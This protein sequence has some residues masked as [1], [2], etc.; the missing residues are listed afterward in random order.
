MGSVKILDCT[1]RDGGCV[2]DFAFGSKNIK[3]ILDC[4]E[5]SNVEIIECGYIDENGFDGDRTKFRSDEVLNDKYLRSRGDCDKYYVAM[6]DYGKFDVNN[7]IRKEDSCLD[8]IRLA[9]HKEKID[10]AIE[11]GRIILEKGYDLYIQ[12]MVTLRYSDREIVEL[13]DKVNI[14]LHEAKAFYMV[15][16]FGEMRMDDVSRLF[17]IIDHNLSN[18]IAIGFHSHNNLQLSYPNAV[19]LLKRLETL[20]R[21]LII[22]SCIMGM[23]KGAGNLCTEIILEHLN[24]YYKKQYVI[25]PVLHVI[26]DVIL[27]VYEDYRWGYSV[28][29]FLSSNAHCS[30]SY[31]SYF[32][33]K[34]TLSIDQ[35]RTLLLRIEPSKRNSFDKQYAEK[36]YDA[37]NID[38]AVLDDEVLERL[39]SKIIGKEVVLIAPG[40]HL[41]DSTSKLKE[42]SENSEK[43]ILIS[44]NALDLFSTDY[45]LVTKNEVER[46]IPV[47]DYLCKKIIRTSNVLQYTDGDIVINYNSWV[48]LGENNGDSSI[49]IALN[50]LEKIGCKKVYLAGFDGFSTSINDNYMD[51]KYSKRVSPNQAIERNEYIRKVI[52]DKKGSMEFVFMTV[53]KYE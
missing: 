44:L 21:D 24:K 41:Q 36:L 49:V 53:S 28:E 7:L 38:N 31:A 20:D 37:F 22:D 12:P 25:G 40:K 29:F 18:S 39:S 42:M 9:F 33:N 23:G 30:P 35:L 26:D 51:K 50:L 46:D 27:Q 5:N 17:S 48:N 3:K 10:E 19:E 16:S 14:E 45:A 52:N 47:S 1:L 34:H 13:I 2:N 32:F 6:I 8:G 11:Y 43:F 4:L 15:D